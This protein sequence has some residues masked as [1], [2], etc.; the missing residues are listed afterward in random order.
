MNTY[1]GI[2]TFVQGKVVQEDFCPRRQMSNGQLSMQTLLQG[3]FC[4]RQLLQGISLPKLLSFCQAQP[5]LQLQL[6]WAGLLLFSAYP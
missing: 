3:Y 1:P 2:D 5:Q 4:P 6:I